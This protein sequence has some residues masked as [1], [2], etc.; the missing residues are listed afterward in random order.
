MSSSYVLLAALMAVAT[1]PFRAIP[2]LV[3]QMHRL[4][5][6]LQA[7]LRLVGP[8]VLA[9]LAAVSLAVTTDDSGRPQLYVGPE[10][11]AVALCVAI[12]AWRR[13]LLLGLIVAA[14][15]I[16]VVRALRPRSALAAPAR[17]IPVRRC[18]EDLVVRRH[19]AHE[20]AAPTL[21]EAVK[22]VLGI[23]LRLGVEAFHLR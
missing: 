2:L 14:V 22:A 17:P 18:Q 5:Q 16:A 19:V 10:W 9:S 1:Y 21:L 8:A 11:I 3:P 12:V 15:F 23:F 7:Y 6:L 20:V 4:P 13:N